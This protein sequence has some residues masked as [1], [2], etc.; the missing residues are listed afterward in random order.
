MRHS[1]EFGEQ[2][3]GVEPPRSSPSTLLAASSCPDAAAVVGNRQREREFEAVDP[4]RTA[5]AHLPRRLEV[6]AP[7][8]EPLRRTSA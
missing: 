1:L 6:L 8:G 5:T 2:R 3:R 7:A 4:D